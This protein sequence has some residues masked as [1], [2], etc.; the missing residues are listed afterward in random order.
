MAVHNGEPYLRDAVESV[1]AEE[2]SGFEFIIIDDASSDGTTD[3]LNAL[4]DRRAVVHRNERNLGLTASLNIG[5][6]MAH[7]EFVARIDADDMVFPGR[8]KAQT[9]ALS[10]SGAQICFCRCRIRDQDSGSEW[11]SPEMDWPLIRW[12]SLFDN[13]F[14][15]HPAVMFRRRAIVEAG[16]YDEK[17]RQ[18][19][20]YDLWNRCLVRGFRFVYVPGAYVLYRSHPGAITVSRRAA[21]A[22]AASTI[23]FRAL[24]H[25]FPDASDPALVGL[26]WLMLGHPPMP[27]GD[28]VRFGVDQC[29]KSAAGFIRRTGSGRGRSIWLDVAHCLRRRMKDLDAGLRPVGTR[30]MMEASLRSMAPKSILRS[31]LTVLARR[32]GSKG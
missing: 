7:G 21:Q 22:K 20:D 23:S 4:S 19:Q 6:G 30:R 10:R 15:S 13:A 3:Y 11:M 31:A 8:L 9:D 29:C 27:S 28:A 14:G 17:F 1:L 32:P 26:R 25:S 24:R 5:L 12:R 2:D 16:G 18:A